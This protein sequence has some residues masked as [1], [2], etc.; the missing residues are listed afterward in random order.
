LGVRAGGPRRES[1]HQPLPRRS[2]TRLPSKSRGLWQNRAPRTGDA[3]WTVD[4]FVD[5]EPWAAMP[6]QGVD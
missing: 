1:V 5:Y 4:V 6:F 3:M 2:N